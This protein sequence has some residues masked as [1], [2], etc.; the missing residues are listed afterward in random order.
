MFGRVSK[1][2]KGADCKSVQATVHWFESSPYHHF[3]ISLTRSFAGFFCLT[4]KLAQW[5]LLERV[6]QFHSFF[7]NFFQRAHKFARN[8]MDFWLVG[9]SLKNGHFLIFLPRFVS[10]IF[11][12]CPVL[13]L[14]FPQFLLRRGIKKYGAKQIVSISNP[15]CNLTF[16]PF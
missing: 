9:V 6:G 2:L 16:M 12:L 1:W 4:A 10:R 8:S 11:I 13:F 14:F 7:R 15:P 5:E 3:M